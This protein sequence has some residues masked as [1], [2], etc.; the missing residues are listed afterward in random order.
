M[1]PSEL[2][3]RMI[4]LL[5]LPDYRFDL[6]TGFVL[7]AGGLTESLVRYSSST[8][9]EYAN[10]LPV[11]STPESFTLT[12]FAKTLLD[13]FR[14]Y[15]RQDRVVIP[16]L[17]VVDLLFENGTLQKIDSDGF[18]FVDL[19]ECTKKEVVKTGEIRKITACMRV[20]CGITSL[21]GTVR[22]RAL[23][24]LLSLLVH[25]FPKVRRSTA[26]QFY[27]A[28]TTSAEDEESEEMLQIED[29]LANTDWNGP[30]PQL[31][32]IRNELYPLLGL[33]QPVFKSS[34]AK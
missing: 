17:E 19:F 12:D 18:S 22:T 7:A 28:L 14:K 34:T 1:S 27:M 9:L 24:Q 13:I 5:V 20:F 33:K 21:G 30:V 10:E 2:Y 6:L 11:E 26:D 4:K 16:L 23:Y 32:E 3:P 25:S 31:K 29:I 8:L 15:E